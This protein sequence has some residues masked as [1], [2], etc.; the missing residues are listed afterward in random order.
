[1]PALPESTLLVF[2][3]ILHLHALQM[4]DEIFGRINISLLASSALEASLSEDAM[5]LELAGGASVFHLWQQLLFS[6]ND[7]RCIIHFRHC[8]N[9]KEVMQG[10]P[11]RVVYMDS[12][13]WLQQI[14]DIRQIKE[15]LTAALAKEAA[16]R[17]PPVS[18]PVI[19][20]KP[21]W[22]ELVEDKPQVYKALHDH[23]LDTRWVHPST[24]DIELIK[25]KEI[26]PA[27]AA[28]AAAAASSA[29]TS[30]SAPLD[31]AIQMH[32]HYT[33]RASPV[34]KATVQA[35][36]KQLTDGCEEKLTADVKELKYFI[37]GHPPAAQTLGRVYRACNRSL[38][39]S[40]CFVTVPSL[41]G[42]SDCGVNSCS[43]TFAPSDSDP[44]GYGVLPGLVYI[45]TR[46]YGQTSFGRQEFVEGFQQCEYRFWFT[47]G[48]TPTS[49]QL[50]WR[51]AC[52]LQSGVT[53]LDDQPA[54]T[55]EQSC[56]LTPEANACYDL[57]HM[58]VA[59]DYIRSFL[60]GDNPM[61][62]LRL[63]C[64]WNPKTKKAFL[65]EMGVSPGAWIFSECHKLD[66][67]CH[68]A[69]SLTGQMKQ[70]LQEQPVAL[71]A[72]SAAVAAAA[73]DTAA[74]KS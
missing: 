17:A 6:S 35:I 25:S 23:M 16:D 47:S 50:S 20:P 59:T 67:L 2:H 62:A 43:F 28:A 14:G 44:L 1:M 63:D 41:G 57:A 49:N 29:A 30:S 21:E 46:N 61:P 42:F 60:N 55:V 9:L 4:Q 37:K 72:A 13:I 36:C 68:V 71:A 12:L 27:A 40:H 39:V 33:T 73:A 15:C 52:M 8:S 53:S 26:E 10:V 32:K 64:G 69:K 70:H 5:E 74:A 38:I 3:I 19:L 24:K 34:A 18:P 48:S 7:P 54:I 65:N 66:I 51:Y 45:W 11:L 31:T 58:L 56:A 22:E